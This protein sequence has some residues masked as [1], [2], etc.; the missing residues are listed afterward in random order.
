MI[1]LFAFTVPVAAVLLFGSQIVRLVVYIQHLILTR[2]K[3]LVQV[4][5][6]WKKPVKPLDA[7]GKVEGDI[8]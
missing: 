1:D 6:F 4:Y 3:D 2:P 5:I 7:N 8:N